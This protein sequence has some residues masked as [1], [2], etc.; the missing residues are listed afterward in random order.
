[1][2]FSH[3]HSHTRALTHAC[4]PSTLIHVRH[5]PSPAPTST[6]VVAA[7]PSGNL[8][9]T[10]EDRDS[11]TNRHRLTRTTMMQREPVFAETT[12]AGRQGSREALV[13]QS[14]LGRHQASRACTHTHV[15]DT[16][17][18]AESCDPRLRSVTRLGGHGPGPTAEPGAVT[19]LSARLRLEGPPAGPQVPDQEPRSSLRGAVVG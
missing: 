16:H 6:A 10:H 8:R 19:S 13:L 7:G 2:T 14:V 12:A 5:A 9:Q 18:A 17:T 3:T 1:M 11:A 4:P 15:R